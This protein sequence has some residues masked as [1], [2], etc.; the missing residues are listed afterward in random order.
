MN[1]NADATIRNKRRRLPS[2]LALKVYKNKEM[3]AF[4]KE[5]GIIKRRSMKDLKHRVPIAYQEESQY[6]PDGRLFAIA[7]QDII[8][9]DAKSRKQLSV[10]SQKGEAV[11][12][13]FSADSQNL[14]VLYKINSSAVEEP[15]YEVVDV[16]LQS[17]KEVKRFRLP[18]R[19]IMKYPEIKISPDK[20]LVA[21]NFG[22]KIAVFDWNGKMTW[23]WQVSKKENPNRQRGRFDVTADWKYFLINLQRVEYPSKKTLP[24][25]KFNDE[26]EPYI[27]S[28]KI[29]DDGKSAV[30]SGE[31]NGEIFR[32]FD[33]VRAKLI[34]EK[35]VGGTDLVLGNS[36]LSIIV[37]KSGIWYPN[38]NRID[39]INPISNFN[40]LNAMSYSDVNQEVSAGPIFFSLTSA[41]N[42]K[43]VDPNK[44]DGLWMKFAAHG[45]I[46]I[47]EFD[48][49][50]DGI[51]VGSLG[52]KMNNKEVYQAEQKSRYSDPESLDGSF[53]V[54]AL[55]KKIIF[56]SGEELLVL[57][58][59]LQKKNIQTVT[60]SR[61]N[62]INCS[63]IVNFK[64]TAALYDTST[65]KHKLITLP[66][67]KKA[68]TYRSSISTQGNFIDVHTDMGNYIYDIKN[69]KIVLNYLKKCSMKFTLDEKYF[70]IS[71]QKSIYF[72]NT[73]TWLVDKTFIIPSGR[74]ISMRISPDNKKLLITNTNYQ[75]Q[76]FDL[77]SGSL[78]YT[79][80]KAGYYD[81]VVFDK[82][83]HEVF[84]TV[85]ISE[86]FKSP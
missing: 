54:S 81:I 71:K 46:N 33:L 13:E 74:V 30:A 83:G 34:A 73:K 57:P 3:V 63:I 23:E 43:S 41:Q 20:K 47:Y 80:V 77:E 38:Q 42:W 10:L 52:Y 51:Q 14:I 68:F 9:F 76:L 82:N 50:S 18:I 40:R 8:L 19:T 15:F 75:G 60:I 64:H 26:K 29:S 32:L 4:F 39:R 79:L 59:D 21:T 17:L 48:E 1:A 6:S 24:V 31:G 7:A 44:G 55:T 22:S 84:S 28:A 12:I 78:I 85:K 70:I 67:F 58:K 66:G 53:T 35:K 61:N 69:K 45:I 65:K 11:A 62:I 2:D 27:H 5:K 16:E 49:G 25:V 56:K 36:D 37:G 72:Y 86:L